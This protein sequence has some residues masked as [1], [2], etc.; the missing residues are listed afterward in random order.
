MA[1]TKETRMRSVIYDCQFYVTHILLM[2]GQKKKTQIE[3]VRNIGFIR[4]VDA[5][6]DYFSTLKPNCATIAVKVLLKVAKE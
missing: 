5:Q 6:L 1:N 2:G 4:S 3:T